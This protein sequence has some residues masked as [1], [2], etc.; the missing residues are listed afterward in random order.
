MYKRFICGEPVY[1]VESAMSSGY[2]ALCINEVLH[3]V[4]QSCTLRS[5]LL[6]SQ[7]ARAF[8]PGTREAIRLRI[9]NQLRY[10]TN[11]PVRL[12]CIMEER[13]AAII[14]H[15][16]FAVAMVNE[17]VRP[18]ENPIMTIAVPF[19]EGHAFRTEFFGL[20]YTRLPYYKE[21]VEANIEEL[22]DPG[23]AITCH[24]I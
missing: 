12:R 18:L 24:P 14:D 23:G 20:G 21:D 5:L 2:R 19:G 16:P 11:N 15:V 1:C 6:L 4:C 8:T 22:T 17:D 13:R 10:F 7:L 9:D 3:L